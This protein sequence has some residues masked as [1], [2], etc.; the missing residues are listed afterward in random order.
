MKITKKMLKQL[1]KEELA[2]VL[3]EQITDYDAED[4]A[5]EGS[6]WGEE[7]FPDPY[8]PEALRRAQAASK[9][10]MPPPREKIPANVP[11]AVHGGG[12]T[13]V[14]Q[15]WGKLAL[16]PT[17]GRYSGAYGSLARAAKVDPEAQAIL[18]AVDAELENTPR[19]GVGPGAAGEGEYPTTLGLEEGKIT[20][21]M[22][23]QLIKEEFLRDP[24]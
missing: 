3:Q 16:L 4:P 20:K 1:I 15:K 2:N 12:G 24:D 6:S 8:S 17:G 9:W 19:R 13:D 18:D 5:P 10:K 22:L 21:R 23:K 14:Y 11:H 7:E